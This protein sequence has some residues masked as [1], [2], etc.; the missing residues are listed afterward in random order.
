MTNDRTTRQRVNVPPFYRPYPLINLLSI[1][2][3]I[4]CICSLVHVTCSQTNH[5]ITNNIVTCS[6]I[7][8]LLINQSA[9]H[10]RKQSA[11]HLSV[12]SSF[13]SHQRTQ[14]TPHHI[15]F[16]HTSVIC[17]HIS[18]KHTHQSPAHTHISHPYTHQSSAHTYDTF[19]HISLVLTH[20]SSAYT[21]SLRTHLRAHTEKQY[22]GMR[23][24]CFILF[25][26]ERMSMC[27]GIKNTSI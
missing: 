1:I 11:D 10:P 15:V 26:F 8:P 9:P 17:S 3:H 16:S 18:H 4:I 23:L 24:L 19:S 27:F 14:Q 20:Q 21:H 5:L 25:Y 6:P 22:K 12:T 13:I 7:C 2:A